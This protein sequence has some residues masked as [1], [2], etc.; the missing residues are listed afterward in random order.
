[1]EIGEFDVVLVCNGP[2]DVVLVCNGPV[3]ALV[4]SSAQSVQ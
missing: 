3:D 2:V 4:E 1:M